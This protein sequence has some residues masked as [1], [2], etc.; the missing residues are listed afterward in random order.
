MDKGERGAPAISTRSGTHYL[1]SRFHIYRSCIFRSYIFSV[2][3]ASSTVSIY[4][5]AYNCDD[6]YTFVVVVT[7]ETLTITITV[8]EL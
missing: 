7:D 5:G 2:P 3:T 4:N 6:G 1:Y 8:Q